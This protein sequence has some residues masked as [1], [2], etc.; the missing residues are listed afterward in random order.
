MKI[1]IIGAGISG[2]T[3]AHELYREHDI[4][5]FE[6]NSYPGG[7]SNTINVNEGNKSV[8]IDTGFIVLNNWTYP[9][10]EALLDTL[11]VKVENSEMSFSAKCEQSKF[12]WCGE[13]IQGLVLN[14]YNWYQLKSYKILFDFLRF[15]KLA[16][17]LVSQNDSLLTLGDFLNQ[18]HFSKTFIKYYILPMGAA[19]WSS[20]TE[21]IYD[22]PA[23]SFLIFF[24]NHGLLNLIDRPQW[25]TIV[26]GSRQYVNKLIEPFS[27]KIIL[28]SSISH[29]E[30]NNGHVLIHHQTKPVETFD[31][32][33]FA[34]HSDQALKLLA[35]PT[36][37]E[38]KTLEKIRYQYNEAVLHTDDSLMPNNKKAWSSWNY[39]LPEQ[40][41]SNAKVTY[42]MN[43]L[44]PLQTHKDYFVSLNLTDRINPKKIIRTIAYQHP[45]FDQLAIR[46]QSNLN[47]L[48]GKQHT[49]FCGAYWRNGFHE[50][51]VWS[52]LTTIEKFKKEVSGEQL[53]L[54]RTG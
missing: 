48:N 45:V 33:I 17:K 22:Y 2:L 28:N 38:Q 12:E 5:V 35:Q 19:I 20:S 8:A 1:A 34:C 50:D 36:D 46:S 51:G 47:K 15:N 42:Y 26:G 27:E 6:K 29:I 49:W 43:R 24:K 11:K 16:K 21:D 52:A 37:D 7:H 14:K 13:G 32:V 10:F 40:A 9:N 23:Y 18:H 44:Q 25:K 41:S 39:L 30:R 54:Q 31:H 4:C 53:H 3:A